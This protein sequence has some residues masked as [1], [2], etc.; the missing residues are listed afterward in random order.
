MPISEMFNTKLKQNDTIGIPSAPELAISVERNWALLFLKASCI[1]NEHVI[2]PL[3][4]QVPVGI[5]NPLL[6]Y[7]FFVG[8]VYLTT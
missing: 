7:S 3:N 8:L 4:K 2:Q 1:W 6:F 5:L